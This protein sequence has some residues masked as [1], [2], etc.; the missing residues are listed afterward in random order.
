MVAGACVGLLASLPHLLPRLLESLFP[1]ITYRIPAAGRTLFLTIDDSPSPATGQILDVLQRH[2]VTAT[3]FVV[4]DHADPAILKRILAEGHQLGHHM[5]TT[6]SLARLSERQFAD[7]FLS[8][9]RT[10][11]AYSQPRHFRPPNGSLDTKQAAFVQAQGYRIVVGTIFPL[12]H[13]LESPDWIRRLA[14]VLVTD[15]GIVILHDTRTRGPRT[16]EVL[17]RLLPELQQRG[18]AFGR[19]P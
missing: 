17:E 3:F 9:H 14:R 1:G 15:G 2:G 8:A 16:A 5:K 11:Q 18:Y 7:D 4:T 10:L 12:D 13:W 19:L 6:A